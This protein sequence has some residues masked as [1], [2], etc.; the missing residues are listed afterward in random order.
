MHADWRSSSRGGGETA[1]YPPAPCCKLSA[2]KMPPGGW[3]RGPT[4]CHSLCCC[5]SAVCTEKPTF[6]M[7]SL[8][9][10]REAAGREDATKPV[11]SMFLRLHG[12]RHLDTSPA[13][14]GLST[15]GSQQESPRRDWMDTEIWFYLGIEFLVC[16]RRVAHCGINPLWHALKWLSTA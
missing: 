1:P 5:N 3:Q 10:V 7:D 15:R 8:D 9:F 14:F 6:G 13:I 2:T 12:S 11:S 16:R 4:R